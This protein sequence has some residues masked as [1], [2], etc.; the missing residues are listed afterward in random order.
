MCG[1]GTDHCPNGKRRTSDRATRRGS[2]RFDVEQG[3]G[4]WHVPYTGARGH[5]WCGG[6]GATG[7]KAAVH[8]HGSGGRGAWAGLGKQSYFVR[9]RESFI[10]QQL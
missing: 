9:L 10:D 4:G 6:F 7:H 3:G 2:V 1:W 8:A 5:G